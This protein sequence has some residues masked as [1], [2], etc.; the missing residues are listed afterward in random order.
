MCDCYSPGCEICDETIPVHIEDFNFPR[1]EV[2]VFCG[3]HLPTARA[4]IFEVTTGT[5]EKD[6]EDPYEMNGYKC[7]IR[8][9][10]GK[11][12]SESA[13]VC[14]NICSGYKITVLKMD[15]DTQQKPTVTMTEIENAVGDTSDEYTEGVVELFESKGFEVEK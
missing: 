12:E 4:T 2:K 6:E 14:P 13:G 11:I 1:D 3:K 10:D 9:R 7:A 8:L 15:E 5:D